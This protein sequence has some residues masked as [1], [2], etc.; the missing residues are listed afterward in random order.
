M[1]FASDKFKQARRQSY[2][3]KAEYNSQEKHIFMAFAML[4]I[5]SSAVRYIAG[6]H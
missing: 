6:T 1:D 3:I 4:Y 2:Y 5:L